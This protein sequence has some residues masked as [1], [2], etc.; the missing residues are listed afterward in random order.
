MLNGP[1][2]LVC[3][4][5]SSYSDEALKAADQLT[6]KTNGHLSVLHVSEHPVIFDW[7]PT[8]GSPISLDE[9]VERELLGTL[10]KKLEAQMKK[11]GVVA[12]NHIT[13]GFPANVILEEVK[14]KNINIVVTGHKG[15]SESTFRIGSLAEKIIAS[16]PVPVMVI[17]SPFQLEKVGALLDPTG[18]MEN[19]LAWAEDLAISFSSRLE[20]I[21]LFPDIGSRFIGIGKIGFSTELLSLSREQGEEVIHEVKERIR[22]HLTRVKDASIR[23]DISKEKKLAYHLNTV[24]QTEKIDLAVMKR[25]QAGFLEKIL[26]GSETRRMLEIFDGNLF[27]LP[28]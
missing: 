7:L 4:D 28:P 24:L 19:I 16:S 10:R 13:M 2:I 5:F 11:C 3:T 15:K 27:I 6:K 23:V 26:I 18:K 20:V 22:S 8:E 12:E 21:S 1:H 14:A 17:K 9:N 25:H